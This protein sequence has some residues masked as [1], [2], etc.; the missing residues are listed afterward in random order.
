M[1][2][3]IGNLTRKIAAVDTTSARAITTPGKPTPAGRRIAAKTLRN[4]K[5][6]VCAQLRRVPTVTSTADHGLNP[7]V[8]T[9]HELPPFGGLLTLRAA[10]WLGRHR[11]P[12]D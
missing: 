4:L 12:P 2:K 3:G 7:V 8:L 11:L 6:D 1:A 9:H 5:I 10:L